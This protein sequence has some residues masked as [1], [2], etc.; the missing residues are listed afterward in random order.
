MGKKNG[1]IIFLV[2]LV[3]VVIGSF[4]GELGAKVSYLQW[5]SYGQTFRVGTFNMPI[6]LDFGVFMFSF[7]LSIKISISSI[8]GMILAIIIYKKI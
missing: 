1:W 6:T 2:L 8:I 4:L 5:L 3:G 7:Y